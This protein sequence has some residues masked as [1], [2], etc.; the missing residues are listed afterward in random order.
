MGLLDAVTG[1][2][3]GLT[4]FASDFIGDLNLFGDSNDFISDI[5]G[6]AVTNSAIAAISGGDIGKAAM[7]GAVGGAFNE[8]SSAFGSLGGY[9]NEISGAISG[10]GVGGTLGALGGAASA[11][12]LD[13]MDNK[14]EP[15]SNEQQ[16]LDA[17]NGDGASKTAPPKSASF[18]DKMVEMGIMTPEGEGTLLGKG[19]L[20]GIAGMASDKMQNDLMDKQQDMDQENYQRKNEI[21]RESEQKRMGAFTN[22]QS[23][24]KIQ[25]SH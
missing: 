5:L 20:G 8:G 7:F 22:G 25:R 19:L 16:T 13:S 21:D 1:A 6:G 4:D 10:Y 3:T 18:K 15:A 2:A 11:Y 17:P 12:G 9:G 24:F 23:N 14:A